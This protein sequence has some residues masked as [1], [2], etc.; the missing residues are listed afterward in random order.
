MIGCFVGHAYRHY[1]SD[2]YFDLHLAPA[3]LRMS[4]RSDQQTVTGKAGQALGNNQAVE[5]AK[6]QWVQAV[7]E[8]RLKWRDLA[9]DD[10]GEDHT[11][12]N[13]KCQYHGK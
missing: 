12:L 4:A 7:V 8:R 13:R 5:A 1:L 6:F 10:P 11:P 2:P 3:T 9:A